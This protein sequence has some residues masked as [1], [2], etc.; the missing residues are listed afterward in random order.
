MVLSDLGSRAACWREPRGGDLKLSP[1]LGDLPLSTVSP[2]EGQSP[3][4]P[5]L[6]VDRAPSPLHGGAAGA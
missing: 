6:A 5:A 4:D 3:A 1:E 2:T